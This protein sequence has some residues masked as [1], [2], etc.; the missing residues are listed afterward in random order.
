MYEVILTP[1]QLKQEV[2]YFLTQDAFAFDIESMDGEYPETRGVPAH[3]RV[4]WISMAT[5]GRTIV[6][7]MGH[8]NGSIMLKRAYK[9]KI[10]GKFVSFPAKFSAP[11]EQMRPSVVYDILWPLFFNPNII[12]IAHN[13]VTDFVSV[14][15]GFGA[16]PVG[17]VHDTIVMQWMLDENIGSVSGGPKR[18][19]DKGLKTLTEWYYSI[20]YDEEKVGACIESHPFNT[21]ARYAALD[22]RYTWLLWQRF[23]SALEAEGLEDHWELERQ[24]TEVLFYM[25]EVGAPIDVDAIEK[26]RILLVKKMA[27]VS[28]K[29]YTVAGREFNIN[30]PVQRQEILYSPKK[31]GGQGLK[32]WKLTDT[33]KKRKKAGETPTINFYSTDKETLE[34][35][36]NNELCR[37]L[38]EY[39]EI[40]KLYGTYVIGYLGEP[41][42]PKKPCRIF[43]GRI[44]AD[45]V[46]YGTVTSR[47]SCREPNLQN[48]PRPGTELG[49][50]VRG[51]FSAPKGYKLVVADYAQVEYR[52]LAHYLRRG[53]LYD[54]FHAGVDAHKATASSMYGVPIEE[55]DKNMRQDSKALG[56]GVLFGAMEAKIAA[57]MGKSVAYAKDRIKEYERT[58]P[59]VS[60]FKRKVWQ[61]A[62]KRK[63]PHI[64]TITGFKRRVWDLTSSDVK[65][66]S[67]AER[68]IFNSLIQGGAAGLI[69][70]A[71][72]RIHNA[73][74]AD[75]LAHPNTDDW[76]YLI[77]SV[78]DELVLLAPDHRA[79]EAKAML[80]EAMAG[81]DIQI[82][83]VPLEADAKIVTRWSDAK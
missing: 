48:I 32:P 9:K 67:R 59:E 20:K 70:K 25:N 17:P 29:I 64:R 38:L 8:P 15:K 68:Q 2:E 39:Q 53:V 42:D 23:R 72:L 11:P 40:S 76:I 24:L 77:L 55:V 63:V 61:E 12:K 30:S 19:M 41:D 60:A 35:Y 56:F 46:Q 22:S 49:T 81:K 34:S 28:A 6:I 52:V 71:M 45:L 73:L 14:S 82:L 13:A 36:P 21:V 75:R 54:G 80:E 47:F 18:P 66:R 51:L 33:G 27:E 74:M 1:E 57:T 31:E 16:I 37:V 3:N 43:D 83:N 65:H 4:V 26:L 44:H 78:H 79:E 10:D 58:Q 7:P 62:R 50:A 69:K 5:Y